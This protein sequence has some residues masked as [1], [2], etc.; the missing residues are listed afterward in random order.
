MMDVVRDRV[1]AAMKFPKYKAR[2]VQ[3][4]YD[5]SMLTQDGYYD[6]DGGEFVTTCGTLWL[7]SV[8]Q[9]EGGQKVHLIMGVEG[10]LAVLLPVEEK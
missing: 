6:E 7:T 4:D 8:S 9:I 3:Y 1:E 10:P 5:N 2:W